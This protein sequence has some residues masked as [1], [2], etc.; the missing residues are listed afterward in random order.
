[1]RPVVVTL[2][3]CLVLIASGCGDDG[4]EVASCEPDAFLPILKDAFDDPAAKLV[5]VEA[6]V[7]RCRNGFARVFAVPDQSACEPGVGGCFETEQ[8]F[9]RDADGEWEILTSG[10][11]IGCDDVDLDPGL[12]DACAALDG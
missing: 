11:G 4:T 7:E 9:L 1:M 2:L 3:A 6:R 12:A 8:V 5:V 10:T